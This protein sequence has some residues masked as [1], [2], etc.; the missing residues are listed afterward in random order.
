MTKGIFQKDRALLFTLIALMILMITLPLQAQEQA[1]PTALSPVMEL[2]AQDNAL[3]HETARVTELQVSAES[4]DT[5][6]LQVTQS[7][8]QDAQSAGQDVQSAAQDAQSAT[9][10]AQSATQ[11]NAAT[12]QQGKES[13]GDTKTSTPPADNF[14][15]FK[16]LLIPYIWCATTSTDLKVRD[17][18]ANAVIT[19]GEAAKYL[20]GAIAA[21]IEASQGHFGGFIDINALRLENTVTPNYRNVTMSFT[22]GVNNYGLFY[23]FKGT[24]VFDIYAGARTYDFTTDLNIEPGRILQGRSISRSRN[25]T[26][27]I[28]GA[29][30]NAP[31]SKNLGIIVSGDVGGISGNS[32]S[33]QFEGLVEWKLSPS[34]SLQ[35]GYKSLYFENT[36]DSNFIDNISVKSRMYGPILKLQ[37]GF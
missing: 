18:T 23:R 14:N 7:A 19:P 2:T 36:Y 27:L 26:D 15:K 11:D 12:T 9:Q 31:L 24:P 8:G 13:T 5:A 35:G 22:S 17:R 3:A 25:W 1:P 4:A 16:V 6:V 37:F 28:I 30:V 10:E 32:S 33:W 29:R 21:R 20:Q 34:F